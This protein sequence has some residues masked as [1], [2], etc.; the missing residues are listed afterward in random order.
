MQNTLNN[1]EAGLI[2]IDQDHRV[3][4]MN[5]KAVEWLG[6]FVQIGKRRKCYRTIVYSKDFCASCPTGRTIDY[7]TPTHYEFNLPSGVSTKIS[8]SGNPVAFEI[9]GIPVFDKDRHVSKVIELILDI[10]EKSIE[11]IMSEELMVHIE[12]MAAIGQLAAGV[13]HELNTPLATISIISEELNSITEGLSEGRFTRDE[14]RDYLSDIN[15]EIKRCQTIIGDLLSF[16]KK[17]VSEHIETDLN[18][19]VSKAINLI[20]KG[21]GY[22][23]VTILKD[24]DASAPV[25]KTDPGRFKQ[26]V[27]N[28]LKNAVEAVMGKGDG[29]VIVYTVKD[30]CSAKV[31]VSDNGPGIPAE[32]LKKVFEPFFTTKP[33]GKGTGLGLS[34][35]YGIMRDL[36]GDIKINSRI[37]EG[38]EVSLLLPTE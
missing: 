13:A 9:I 28:V 6:P 12:K 27:F 22:K 33:V 29:R 16:S 20:Q 23:G 21:E 34:V 17:G 25:V 18:S 5:Q 36:M 11:K 4:W 15:S 31:V 32:N 1:L 35:S 30:G 24:F 26:V 37:G 3:E 19:L 2:I 7:G 8:E 14:L 38:V 10:T